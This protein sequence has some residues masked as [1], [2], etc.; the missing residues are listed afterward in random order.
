MSDGVATD[1]SAAAG[2]EPRDRPAPQF[3]VLGVDHVERAAAP[4]LR[5]RLAVRD[6]SELRVYT[7]ALSVLIAIEPAKR[8]YTPAERVRLVEL[9][10][11][12]ERWASTTEGFRWAQ[13]DVLVP[14]FSVE[15]E[16]EVRVP[17]TYDHEVAAGKYLGGLEDGEAPL[18][19]HLNGTVFYEA[20]GGRLQMIAIPWD[21]SVRYSMPIA[22][23]RRMIE[24]H[25][26]FRRWI[27]LD[28]DT[29][30]RLA[31]RRAAR[32]LPSFDACLDELLAEAD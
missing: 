9:F 2:P 18:R 12:P 21:C 11:E 26:P 17:C 7:I 14:G 5:F 30:D 25:Y 6:P 10:G 1:G 23:W 15:T 32:G 22:A 24:D 3:E 20:G 16:F 13:V 31:R 4:T 27:A 28:P 8:A 19:L 29:V